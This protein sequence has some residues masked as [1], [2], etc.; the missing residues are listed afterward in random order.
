MLSPSGAAGGTDVTGG[1]CGGAP[2]D[3]PGAAA[4][5]AEEAGTATATSS[6]L[7]LTSGTSGSPEEGVAPL[8]PGAPAGTSSAGA[9]APAA[10]T[11]ALSGLTLAHICHDG[12]SA[13]RESYQERPAEAVDISLGPGAYAAG[14]RA[15]GSRSQVDKGMWRYYAPNGTQYT[16]VADAREAR[17]MAARNAGRSGHIIPTDGL[18]LSTNSSTG[19]LG[20]TKEQRNNRTLYRANYLGQRRYASSAVEAAQMYAAMRDGK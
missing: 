17:G 12:R 13:P 9:P 1:G 7:A 18:Y 2:T 10:G 3:E 16:T 20:V 5:P 15:R 8:S 11:L 14:W 6:L 4:A 19:Y